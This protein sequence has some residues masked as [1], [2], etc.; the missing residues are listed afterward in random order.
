MRD[1]KD[2]N[3]IDICRIHELIVADLAVHSLKCHY[4][5]TGL[6]LVG[7]IN[8]KITLADKTGKL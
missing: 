1:C 3:R 8:A 4:I 5:D 7:G 2:Y 6:W